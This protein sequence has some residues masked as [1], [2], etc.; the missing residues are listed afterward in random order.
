VTR[1]CYWQVD[2]I[3]VTFVTISVGVRIPP[4][5]PRRAPSLSWAAPLRDSPD[6]ALLADPAPGAVADPVEFPMPAP[7]RP[8]RPSAMVPVIRTR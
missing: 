5:W 4:V 3:I 7:L 8:P 6:P 1:H 2:E